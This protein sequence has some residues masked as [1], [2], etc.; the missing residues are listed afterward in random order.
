MKV[1][2]AQALVHDP[3]HLILDEPSRGLDVMVHGFYVIFCENNGQRAPVFCFR[4]TLCKKWLHYA[5]E[6]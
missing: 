4:A 5:T 3:K 2:L 1:A 6:S